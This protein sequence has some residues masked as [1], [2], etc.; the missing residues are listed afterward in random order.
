MDEEYESYHFEDTEFRVPRRYT[1]LSAR[2][3]GAQGAVW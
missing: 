3:I 1:E 2:G